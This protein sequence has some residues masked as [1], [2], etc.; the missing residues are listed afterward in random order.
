LART[1]SLD[2]SRMATTS[3]LSRTANERAKII[4]N[5]RNQIA[6]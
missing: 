5:Y 3:G 2:V 1:D 4:R 6:T